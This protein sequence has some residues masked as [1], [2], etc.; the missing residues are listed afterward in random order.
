MC[1][2]GKNL[3]HECKNMESNTIYF[4]L[5]TVSTNNSEGCA[6][7]KDEQRRRA[8]DKQKTV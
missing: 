5:L 8:R 4:C 3:R 1:D 2:A 6:E 7:N